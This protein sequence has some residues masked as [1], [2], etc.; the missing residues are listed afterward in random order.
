MT[1]RMPDTASRYFGEMAESY[2]S[3][4]RRAVPSYDLM[5]ERTL[6][7]LPAHAGRILELGCGTGNFTLGLAARY[8]DA[9]LVMVDAAPEMTSLTRSRLEAADPAAAARARFLTTRFELLDPVPGEFELVV[10]CISLHHVQDKGAL[11]TVLRRALSNGGRFCFA[12]QLR[13]PAEDIQALNWNR[14]LDYCRLPGGCS[15][16][17]IESLLEHA[18]KHDHYTPLREHI[19]LLEAAGFSQVDCVWRDLAWGVVTADAV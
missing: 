16:E 7:Y 3:L 15:E 14:W 1:I 5:I 10:S 2:D 19:R 12:D 8:P 6:E 17:E 11:Y 9:A 18:A 4:I 13:A